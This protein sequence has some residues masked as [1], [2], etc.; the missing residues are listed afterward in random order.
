MPAVDVRFRRGERLRA[1]IVD[2][3]ATA[4]AARL[5]DRTGKELPVPV[6]VEPLTDDDGVRWQSV[7]LVLAPL[8]VGDYVVEIVRRATD[9]SGTPEA[10]L[11]P[12]R[13]VP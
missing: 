6:N 10:T 11:V 4:V 7:Q 13:I 5:V 1:D 2:V 9:G 3:P 8:A 12:F